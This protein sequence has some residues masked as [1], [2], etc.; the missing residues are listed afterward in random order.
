MHHEHRRLNDG[1][2]SCDSA[3]AT[4][5]LGVNFHTS[6]MPF[7]AQGCTG[8]LSCGGGQTVYDPVSKKHVPAV[9]DVGN[10]VCRPDPTGNGLTPVTPDQVTLDPTKR[11]YISVLPGDAGNPFAAGNTMA[12][13]AA[14]A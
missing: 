3:A 9:C 8:P 4:P 14:G 5:A 6:H 13:C 11:Y 10:G 1:L 2:S 12:I 7:V